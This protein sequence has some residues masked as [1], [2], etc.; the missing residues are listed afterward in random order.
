MITFVN[1]LWIKK[2]CHH[3]CNRTHLENFFFNVLSIQKKAPEFSGREAPDWET[4]MFSFECHQ[5]FS[6][7]QTAFHFA[8]VISS[9]SCLKQQGGSAGLALPLDCHT[10]S[11][12]SNLWELKKFFVQEKVSVLWPK[13][14]GLLRIWKLNSWLCGRWLWT[15][16]DRSDLDRSD[17]DSSDLPRT[18]LP[19]TDLDRADH[20]RTDLDSDKTDLSWKSLCTISK[21]NNPWGVNCTLPWRILSK[22]LTNSVPRH[23]F[24]LVFWITFRQSFFPFHESH[25]KSSTETFFEIKACARAKVQEAIWENLKL[26]FCWQNFLCK[27][28]TCPTASI[29]QKFFTDLIFWMQG[30]RPLQVKLLQNSG[31]G[32]SCSSYL[33]Y[34][35]NHKLLSAILKT[36]SKLRKN[37]Q[38]TFL[39]LFCNLQFETSKGHFWLCCVHSLRANTH[40][41][42]CVHTHTH[43]TYIHTYTNTHTQPQW[44]VKQKGEPVWPL[45]HTTC[46]MTFHTACARACLGFGTHGWS[47]W[48]THTSV[49]TQPQMN[50]RPIWCAVTL[51]CVC[52][53]ALGVAEGW[54]AFLVKFTAVHTYTHAHTHTRTHATRVFWWFS[55]L[56]TKGPKITV[57][58]KT[59]PDVHGSCSY[60]GRFFHKLSHLVWQNSSNEFFLSFLCHFDFR[61]Q[62]GSLSSCLLDDPKSRSVFVN[63][64]VLFPP[65]TWI[66]WN[67]VNE[68]IILNMTETRAC[69]VDWGFWPLTSWNRCELFSLLRECVYDA[70]WE[71]ELC[72]GDGPAL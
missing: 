69:C 55:R 17:L 53:G 49:W 61:Q 20:D 40:R 26:L 33:T 24:Q 6:S 54:G 66:V 62:T 42:T 56:V 59:A 44:A 41:R 9:D 35:Q 4:K 23:Q 16:L 65:W 14:C 21:T 34:I 29:S 3:I 32:T 48:C 67:P 50:A 12:Y 8:D 47:W 46:V 7:I 64:I 25:Q 43:T 45:G 28:L 19:R 68:T 31:M 36:V 52:A 5:G 18:D 15:G 71:S 38:Y 63:F 70:L 60:G 22:H 11:W 27:F 2:I 57:P 72:S 51:T 13:V 30:A 39:F 1:F 10:R 37:C 58:V